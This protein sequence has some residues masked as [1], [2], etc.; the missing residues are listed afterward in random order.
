M[1][2]FRDN[3]LE[4]ILQLQPVII[5]RLDSVV[6]YVDFKGYGL[7]AGGELPKLT[8]FITV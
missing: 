2:K 8:N 3:T 1:A 7:A 6:L 5:E 4:L